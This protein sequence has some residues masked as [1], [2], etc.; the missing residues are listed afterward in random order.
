MKMY[1]LSLK[2]NY[3][4]I[5]VKNKMRD[6]E[7]LLMWNMTEKEKNVWINLMKKWETF[8]VINN[9]HVTQSLLKL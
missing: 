7:L 3:K 4:K 9:F 2:G 6:L 8:H 1:F 5:Y